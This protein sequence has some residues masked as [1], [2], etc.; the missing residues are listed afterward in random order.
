MSLIYNCLI[1][2]QF[3]FRQRNKALDD[4]QYYSTENIDL[5]DD[6]KVREYLDKMS[7]NNE[8]GTIN[9]TVTNATATTLIANDNVQ[10]NDF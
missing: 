4:L 6:Y 9:T 3:F 7:T 1:K 10:Y 2:L 8:Q 5:Q